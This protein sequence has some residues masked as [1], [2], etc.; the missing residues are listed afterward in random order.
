MPYTGTT[1]VPALHMAFWDRNLSS[2]AGFSAILCPLLRGFTVL[3]FDKRVWDRVFH[4]VFHQGMP[5]T[6]RK[7][8]RKR[9]NSVL[10][11]FLKN[12]GNLLTIRA[13][14]L[15]HFS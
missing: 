6:M 5:Y 7:I 13:I 8:F 3:K 2:I 4:T 11:Y 9:R 12:M 15:A 10:N 14:Q 1:V